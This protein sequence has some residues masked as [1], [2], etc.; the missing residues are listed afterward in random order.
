[1]VDRLDP[2]PL[3]PNGLASAGPWDPQ[4]PPTLTAYLPHGQRRTSACVS[5]VI[6]A[7]R[8][9]FCGICWTALVFYVGRSSCRHVCGATV[10][11]A[12][13]RFAGN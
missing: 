3:W 10:R 13:Y 6:L 2:I 5:C 9:R 12:C 8:C 7:T 11:R 1:M 4:A